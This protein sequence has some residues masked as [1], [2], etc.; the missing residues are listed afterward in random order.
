MAFGEKAT[1]GE[2]FGGRPVETLAG[3]EHCLLGVEHAL[4]RLVDGETFGDGRQ[5]LAE[6][7]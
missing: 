1:E 2:R 6:A 4:Q 3:R 7:L 5:H